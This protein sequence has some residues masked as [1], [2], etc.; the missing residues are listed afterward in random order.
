MISKAAL[1]V[2]GILTSSI[3]FAAPESS[4]PERIAAA[5]ALIDASGDGENIAYV[6]SKIPLAA[7]TRPREES[8]SCR[9]RRVEVSGIFL[10]ERVR[11]MKTDL[12][13]AYASH[14]TVE[15]SRRVTRFFQSKAG[16]A[17]RQ[18]VEDANRKS[19][20]PVAILYS[21]LNRGFVVSGKRIAPD[22]LQMAVDRL[23]PQDSDAVVAFSRTKSGQKF[24][25]DANG[26]GDG[27]LM[28]LATPK[29]M[30]SL[31][32]NPEVLKYKAECL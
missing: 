5:Q 13:Q 25:N 14:L 29:K 23:S 31:K 10:S 16:I 20:A 11:V 21:N 8:E 30:A 28:D 4:S 18:S 7:A 27:I 17:F 9:A 12:V 6:V 1:V 24:F 19:L 22:Q 2:S 3:A 32:D 26:D 15:E